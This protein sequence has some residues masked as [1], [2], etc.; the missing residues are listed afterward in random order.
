MD[1]GREYGEVV[2]SLPGEV[3]RVGEAPDELAL[4]LDPARVAADEDH[5][6]EVGE[7]VHREMARRLRLEQ[8]EY[9]KALS[10]EV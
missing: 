4:D 8:A 5:A 2:A 6:Q 9:G 7:L 1:G 3:A 10:V